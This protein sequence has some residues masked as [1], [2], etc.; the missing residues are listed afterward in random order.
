M[1]REWDKQM[2]VDESLEV[3]SANQDVVIGI[4]KREQKY[5]FLAELAS[6]FG[7]LA[8]E[9]NN[10]TELEKLIDPGAIAIAVQI[11]VSSFTLIEGEIL[12]DSKKW[13]TWKTS[14]T[15]R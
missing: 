14:P 11:L 13:S 5:K 7:E 12:R 10:R 8:H 6:K 1:E 15:G 3:Y 4:L 9:I 2:T